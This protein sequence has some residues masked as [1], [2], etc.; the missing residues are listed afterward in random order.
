MTNDLT[1]NFPGEKADLT[2]DDFCQRC[3]VGT[4]VVTTYVEEGLL[5]V[6][7]PD[8]KSWKFTRTHIVHLQKAHRLQQDLRLN[9]AGTVLVLELQARIEQ[10]QA[11]LRAFEG[12]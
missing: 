9:P 5:S 12:A 11:R 7:G 6:S 8:T 2:I 4:D 10:L 1:N 3:G